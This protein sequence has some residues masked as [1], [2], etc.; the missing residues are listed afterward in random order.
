MIDITID[1]D[2]VKLMLGSETAV[3]REIGCLD[4]RGIRCV[5]QFSKFLI[6]CTV[7]ALKSE[8]ESPRAIVSTLSASSTR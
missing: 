4:L 6:F 7:M 3:E 8:P 2:D 1:C 5:A